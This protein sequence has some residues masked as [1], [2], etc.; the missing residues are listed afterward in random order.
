MHRR[1]LFQ[2]LAFA[3]S[4]FVSFT[5]LGRAQTQPAESCWI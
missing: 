5:P 2:L 3:A 4:S 1:R